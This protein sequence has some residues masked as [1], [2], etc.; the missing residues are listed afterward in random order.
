MTSPSWS[1]RVNALLKNAERPPEHRKGPRPV[2][3]EDR[4]WSKVDT[5]GECWLWTGTRTRR[6]YGRFYASPEMVLA[7]RYSY[8]TNVG[9]V[10][11]GHDVMHEC[12]NPTCVRP[13]HLRAGTRSENLKDMVRRGRGRGQFKPSKQ[14]QARHEA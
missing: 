9:S 10:P 12:D 6:G 7:H 13:S 3:A 4:F 1:H 5:S 11:D 14:W 8:E 2:P